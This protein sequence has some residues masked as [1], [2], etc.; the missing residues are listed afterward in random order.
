[1]S[2]RESN[3]RLPPPERWRGY[4]VLAIFAVFAVVLAVRAFDLQVL[5][6]AFLTH[7]GDKRHLR[8][9]SV[10]AGRGAIKDRNG[11]PL[12]LSAFGALVPS[13]RRSGG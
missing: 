12:A 2:R 3:K 13:R 8:T 5:D 1:M 11:E 7:E 4:F 6:Q 10:P 9:V